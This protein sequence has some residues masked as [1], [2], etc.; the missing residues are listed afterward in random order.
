VSYHTAPINRR[1]QRQIPSKAWVLPVRCCMAIY[2][3]ML[4]VTWS[5]A[6]SLNTSNGYGGCHLT[7]SL[8]PGIYDGG[9]AKQGQRFGGMLMVTG[10]GCRCEGGHPA[11]DGPAFTLL[12]LTSCGRVSYE[13]SEPSFHIGV[14][15]VEAPRQ[16][17]PPRPVQQHLKSEASEVT[18]KSTF[19]GP[20]DA[21][22]AQ[23]V[24]MLRH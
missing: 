2:Q 14:L 1:Q 21:C 15:G 6:P 19:V 17:R 5:G 10:S 8:S 9:T 16:L 4:S 11:I 3:S 23:C 12:L 20:K 24:M 18:L 22:L 13:P 7:S